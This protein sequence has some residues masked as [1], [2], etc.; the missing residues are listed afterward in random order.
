MRGLLRIQIDLPEYSLAGLGQGS[1]KVKDMND[2]S[3]HFIVELD[4]EA[5]SLQPQNIQED[6]RDKPNTFNKQAILNWSPD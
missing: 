6:Y 4:K 3:T 5:N 2:L 1:T